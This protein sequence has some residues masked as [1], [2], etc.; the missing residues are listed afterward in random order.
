MSIRKP[1]GFVFNSRK[2]TVSLEYTLP[3]TGGRIRRRSTVKASSIAEA[4]EAWKRFQAESLPICAEKAIAARSRGLALSAT[5]ANWLD[6]VIGESRAAKAVRDVA[7]FKAYVTQHADGLF[8]SVSNKTRRGHECALRTSLCPF[9]GSMPVREIGREVIDAFQADQ[10]RRGYSAP[11]INAHLALLR[12]VLRYAVAQ[13]HLLDPPVK[14][15][16]PH[17][18]EIPLKLE[19]R[20]NEQAQ[21]EAA[22]DDLEGFVRSVAEASRRPTL[23]RS[24][25]FKGQRRFGGSRR[26]DSVATGYDFQRFSASK[27]LFVLGLETGIAQG[28]LIRLRWSNVFRKEGFIRVRR[29]KTKR[30]AVI[31]IS[32]AC[33]KALE[34]C[35]RKRVLGNEFVFLTDRGRPFSV[36]VVNRY[37]KRAKSIAGITRR[38][39]FHD[40]RHSFG[41]GLAS[42]SVSLQHIQMALGHA[43]LAST[44]RYA[45]PSEESLKAIRK[46]LDSSREEIAGNDGISKSE[47]A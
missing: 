46:A 31:P 2:K 37:F 19:F 40:L 41:S 12:K 30:E 14:G 20:D 16:F 35:S 33:E 45:R 7:T 28:D 42:K 39:R 15:K 11:S 29:K 6:G 27:P 21:F 1:V 34:V 36:A 32:N 5:V 18:P 8:L 17:E 23:I 25:M 38:F 24:P 3:R 13:R 44:Q 4:L 43:D 22:F 9:F 26:P 47:G 10:R